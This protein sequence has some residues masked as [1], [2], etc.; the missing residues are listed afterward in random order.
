MDPNAGWPVS[1]NLGLVTIHASRYEENNKKGISHDWK[2]RYM[3]LGS[4]VIICLH[5][6]NVQF[7]WLFYINTNLYD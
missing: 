6:K 3:F 2:I 1:E 4:H 5:E 7:S